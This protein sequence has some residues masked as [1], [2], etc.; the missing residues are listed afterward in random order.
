MNIKRFLVG[1]GAGVLTVGLT[2][3]GAASA[4]RTS[5]QA[6]VA[7]GTLTVTGTRGNDAL[8]LRLKAGVPGVLQVDVGDDGTAQFEFDRSTFDRIQVL[9]G[10]GN[11]RIRIDQ[12]NGAFADE[13]TTL[14]GGRG[15]DALLGGDGNES[16]R[17]AAGNDSIDG[18]RGADTSDMGGGNDSFTWDPGDGS[19]GIEGR[20]GRDTMVFNGA[21][22]DESFS[23]EAS[24]SRAIFTRNIGNIRMDTGG[25]ET[26]DL[27]MLAGFDNFSVGDF[28]FNTAM[29]RADVDMS[30]AGDG[31]APDAQT[32]SVNLVGTPDEDHITA[33]V[34]R[35]RIEVAGVPVATSIT[36]SAIPDQLQLTAEGPGDTID[37]DPAVDALISV[38]IN[39]HV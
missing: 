39:V 32:D 2:A 26:L 22:V 12:V 37:V 23:L 21:N 10:A 24:G 16:L 15:N 8:A 36:G 38:L 14:D 9:A 28:L 19:D 6:G 18:N 29:N 25:V 33:D 7:D 20:A 4:P 13:A 11:D 5:V 1:A 35:G 17:G 34:R 3:A 31:G 30:A 27:N